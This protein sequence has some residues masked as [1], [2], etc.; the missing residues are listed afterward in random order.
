MR[1]KFLF[2]TFLSLCL[3]SMPLAV[4]F[5]GHLEDGLNRIIVL[6]LN[7]TGN[8]QVHLQAPFA[9][10]TVDLVDTFYIDSDALDVD[11]RQGSSHIAFMPGTGKVQMLGCFDNAATNQTAACNSVGINDVTLPVTSSGVFEF[12]ADNQFRIL[13]LE[14]ST[15]AVADWTV[16]WEYWNGS[17][18]VALANVNDTSEGLTVDGHSHVLF[19]FPAAG[20]WGSETLHAVD[21]YWIRARVSAATT[22]TS[23]PIGAQVWY[24]TGRWWAIIPSIE[25]G[26]Q[27]SYD[28]HMSVG[29]SDK[30]FHYFF[31]HTDGISV[32]DAATIE[33]TGSQVMEFKGYFDT[34]EPVTGTTKKIAFK[35]A[36][37][38]I[39]IPAEGLIQVK[40]FEVP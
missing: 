39:T 8:N 6:F 1:K 35:G 13:H 22:I 30:T 21:G 23:V 20:L 15:P 3:L 10:S 26:Q 34:T 9:L 31:P 25:S 24:E 17:A 28:T 4:V 5:A 36:A 12:A 37:L 14:I 2:F 33:I 29:D 32:A 16:V 40:M 7:P 19:D 38:E 18:Y 11:V 27:V